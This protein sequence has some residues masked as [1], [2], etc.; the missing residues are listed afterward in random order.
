MAKTKGMSGVQESTL[1][2]GKAF[3]G[4]KKP[5]TSDAVAASKGNS[6]KGKKKGY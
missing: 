2:K 5:Q 4:S 3:P 1:E 6:G